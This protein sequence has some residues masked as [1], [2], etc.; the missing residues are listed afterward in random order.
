MP[1]ALPCLALNPFVHPSIR[2]SMLMLRCCEG[3]ELLEQAAD[4]I[5]ATNPSLRVSIEQGSMD[6][7]WDA[8]VVVASVPTLGRAKS[9]R[10]ERFDPAEFKC[11]VID[12]AHHATASTYL[13]I[14]DYFGARDDESAIKVWGC[15][16]TLR[17]HDGVSL[18][19]VFEKIGYSRTIM[20]M[21]DEGWLCRAKP[22]HIETNIDLTHVPVTSTTGDFSQPK[23]AAATNNAKR[24]Q[25]IVDSWRALAHESGRK[26]TL[27]F[28]VDVQHTADLQAA[29]VANG[30]EAYHVHGGTKKL[31]RSEI[32]ADFRAQEFPVLI[33]CGVY[34]EGTDIPCVDCLILA[35]PTK[36]SVLFQQMLGRGLRQHPGKSDCLVLDLVDNIGRN[37]CLTLPSLM[38]LLPSFDAKGE[39]IYDVYAKMQAAIARA[40]QAVL[41]QSLDDAELM[42]ERHE[43]GLAGFQGVAEI[44]SSSK[45][46]VNVKPEKDIHQLTDLPF[47]KFNGDYYCEMENVG[48]VRIWRDMLGHYNAGVRGGNLPWAAGEGGGCYEEETTIPMTSDSLES[49]FSAVKTYVQRVYPSEFQTYIRKKSN[50]F[51]NEPASKKQLE[52]LKRL[53]GRFNI[54][55]KSYSKG[56]ASFLIDKIIGARKSKAVAE[57][58][59]KQKATYS[60]ILAKGLQPKFER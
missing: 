43:L 30:I 42:V 18:G 13:R 45:K 27:V 5:R 14:L 57:K 55:E 34:T 29:F 52:L 59:K 24:N 48:I 31:E 50:R 20:D 17:R 16:A 7:D 11:I 54:D 60:A 32:L 12:E 51:S 3:T 6:A 35:R 40:P 23:L 21:W 41:A 22:K 26:S 9:A 47:A 58:V 56:Q 15:S 37:S 46:L 25:L 38:G 44:I 36:S 39:D 19:A 2:P 1:L 10:I 53:T 4:R 49:A 28:G 33:N 8:D